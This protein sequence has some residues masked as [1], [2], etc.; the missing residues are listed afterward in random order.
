MDKLWLVWFWFCFLA[1]LC[2]DQI[3]AAEGSDPGSIL[4]TKMC[5]LPEALVL[6]VCHDSEAKKESQLV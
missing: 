5:A 6:R 1:R 2:F 4:S 3:K